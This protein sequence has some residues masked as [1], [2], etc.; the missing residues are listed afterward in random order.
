MVRNLVCLLVVLAI[1]SMA[2]AGVMGLWKMNEGTGSTAADSSGYGQ[3]LSLDYGSGSWVLNHPDYG[4]GFSF[5]GTQRFIAA[6]PAGG[7]A[8]DM[9]KDFTFSAE[10][11]IGGGNGGALF[12][13][14]TD[15][16]GWVPGAKQLYVNNGVLNFDCGWVGGLTGTKIVANSVKHTVALNFVAATGTVSLYVD[17]ALD[18]SS[19]AFSGMSVYTDNFDFMVGSGQA[20]SGSL[21]RPMFGIMDNVQ[22]TPEPATL[23]LLGL[24]VVGLLRKKRF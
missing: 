9:S 8:F 5:G 1:G 14:A 3:T 24:G 13:R 2:S 15:A 16:G 19:S 23:A 4:T 7:F 21:Y 17:G 22:I 12:T 20:I 6:K 18:V 10:I 11:Q